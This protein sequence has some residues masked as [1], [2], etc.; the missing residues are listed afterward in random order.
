MLWIMLVLTMAGVEHSWKNNAMILKC[1]ACPTTFSHEECFEQEAFILR[2]ETPVHQFQYL[3]MFCQLILLFVWF[4][5]K[6]NQ[7]MMHEFEF[8]MLNLNTKSNLLSESMQME[9]Y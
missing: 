5:I 9:G 7:L 8:C 6:W 1:S 3:Q 2:T 4:A